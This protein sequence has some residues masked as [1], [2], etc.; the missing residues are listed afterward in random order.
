MFTFRTALVCILIGMLSAP[1]ATAG[2]RYAKAA[3]VELT[4]DGRHWAEQTLKK[5]S[6]EEKVGQMFGVRYYMDFENFS[7]DAYQ[8]FR[9]QMQKY[10]LGTVLLTVRVDGPFLFKNAKC[11][12]V[13]HGEHMPSPQT[14]R[15]CQRR[16]R[17]RP[18][19][20]VQFHSLF[21]RLLV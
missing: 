6:L 1:R 2:E 12:S 9:A 21:A 7:S 18:P 17:G 4:K 5:L 3:P 13:C 8:Q 11:G 14:H 19:T 15:S 16:R 10:H 20:C